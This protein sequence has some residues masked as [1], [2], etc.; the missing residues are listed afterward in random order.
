MIAPPSASC[1][2]EFCS[3]AAIAIA[4]AA[5]PK[6]RYIFAPPEV[7]VLTFSFHPYAA[8]QRRPSIGIHAAAQSRAFEP[9]PH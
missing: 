4:K 6:A 7:E 9:L 5:A 2:A 1:A 3:G 8:E